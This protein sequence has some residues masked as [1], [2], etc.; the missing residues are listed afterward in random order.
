MKS[1]EGMADTVV[2]TNLMINDLNSSTNIARWPLAVHGKMI[3]KTN[4]R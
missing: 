1:H 4:G 2:V 3:P